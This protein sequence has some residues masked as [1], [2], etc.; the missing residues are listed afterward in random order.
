MKRIVR[1][2]A[3][4]NICPEGILGMNQYSLGKNVSLSSQ[5]LLNCGVIAS[6]I[7]AFLNAQNINDR[8]SLF[9]LKTA[10]RNIEVNN[11]LLG[12]LLN[13]LREVQ[14]FFVLSVNITFVMIFAMG[15]RIRKI[16]H[17]TQLLKKVHLYFASLC[18]RIKPEVLDLVVTP[19]EHKK[20]FYSEKAVLPMK[21]TYRLLTIFKQE[22]NIQT[23]LAFLSNRDCEFMCEKVVYTNKETKTVEEFAPSYQMELLWEGKK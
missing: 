7:F 6:R 19:A 3:V 12:E 4:E 22:D 18:N 13:K 2:N 17:I 10:P 5:N 11:L 16:E 23:L 15:G 20:V 14:Y 9:K 8:H 21:L 1:L